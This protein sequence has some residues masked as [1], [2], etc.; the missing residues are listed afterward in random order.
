MAKKKKKKNSQVKTSPVNKISEA[1]RQK[2]KSGARGGLTAEGTLNTAAKKQAREENAKKQSILDELEQKRIARENSP[3][4]ET[5]RQKGLETKLSVIDKDRVARRNVYQPDEWKRTYTIE[6]TRSRPSDGV[7]KAATLTRALDE[8]IQQKR[9]YEKAQA[10]ANQYWKEQSRLAKE[11]GMP[12]LAY[13]KKQINDTPVSNQDIQKY[14]SAQ[15]AKQAKLNSY[16]NDIYQRK[17]SKLNQTAGANHV[18]WEA[19]KARLGDE[20]TVQGYNSMNQG[21]LN[22]RGQGIYDEGSNLIYKS[23]NGL[24]SYISDA[25][26]TAADLREQAED[27]R[28]K[29]RTGLFDYIE[30]IQQDNLERITRGNN[31]IEEQTK[32]NKELYDRRTTYQDRRIKAAETDPRKYVDPGVDPDMIISQLSDAAVFNMVTG[33]DYNTVMAGLNDA[34]KQQVNSLISETRENFR[35]HSWNN[36]ERDSLLKEA[37]AY[38]YAAQQGLNEKNTRNQIS[39][40]MTASGNYDDAAYD[41][42]LVNLT[43]YFADEYHDEAYY[44]PTGSKEDQAYYYM[45]NIP[46]VSAPENSIVNLRKEYFA[47]PEMVDAY[48][49]YYRA[50]KENGTNLAGAFLDAIEPYLTSWMTEYSD[51]F[52]RKK[53]ENPLTGIPMRIMSYPINAVMS[54]PNIINT[55]MA[56]LGNKG[57][58]DPNNGINQVNRF[59]TVTREEQNKDI[60]KALGGNGT[61]EYLLNVA[62]SIGDNVM[63]MGTA[64][65]LVPGMMSNAASQKLG[66]GIVQMIMSGEATGH[67]FLEKLA[68]N[69]NPTEAAW[70]AIG[71]GIIEWFTERVSLEALL[72]PDVKAML[73]DKKKLLKYFGTTAL[74]EGSEE[75]AADFLN[76]G[77]DYIISMAYDHQDELTKRYYEL[78]TSGEGMSARDAWNQALKEK[79]EQIGMSGLAGAISGGLMGMGR[80]GLNYIQNQNLGSQLQGSGKV[81]SLLNIGLQS[82]KGTLSRAN[83]EAIRA[84]QE[85]GKKASNFETGKLAQSIML[86][87]RESMDRKTEQARTESI[88]RDL[89][90]QG[91][92]AEEA[93]SLA[94]TI[95]KALDRGGIE[96]L[97]KKERDAIHGNQAAV[98]TLYKYTFDEQTYKNL[99]KEVNEKTKTEAGA[100]VSVSNMFRKP[101]T[102]NVSYNI[103]GRYQ[104]KEDDNDLQSAEGERTQGARG[105]IVYNGDKVQNARINGLMMEDGKLKWSVTIDGVKHYVDAKQIRTTDAGTAAIIESHANNPGF[106]NQKY[107]NRMLS[108]Y[109]GANTDINPGTFL[110]DAMRIRY[111]ALEQQEMPETQIPAE[112]AQELY[113]TAQTAYEEYRQNEQEKANV[114]KPGETKVYFKGAEAGTTEFDNA[115]N[116]SSLSDREKENIRTWAKLMK[117]AGGQDITFVDNDDIREMQKNRKDLQIFKGAESELYGEQS[118]SGI[119]INIE[120]QNFTRDLETGEKKATGRHNF[121]IALGHE[122]T[123]YIQTHTV[124]GW[125]E[126]SKYVMDEQRKAL[127]AAGLNEAISDYM[128]S[129]GISLEEAIAEYVADSCE[130]IFNNKDVLDHIQQ[131]NKTLFGQIRD[132]VKDLIDRVRNA[133]KNSQSSMTAA[134]MRMVNGNLRELAKRFNLAY[135]EA[136]SGRTENET[137]KGEEINRKSVAELSDGT[138][139]AI[140]DTNL[141]DLKP[142]SM[143]MS[144]F[145]YDYLR[146]H[147]NENEIAQATSDVIYLGADL[148]NEY[149]AS[150]YTKDLIRG[151]RKKL[152]IKNRAAGILLDAIVAADNKNGPNP[153]KHPK[154]KNAK[155]GVYKFNTK[156]AFPVKDRAGNIASYNVYSAQLIVNH[157]SNGKLELYDIM[158]INSDNQSALKM[159]NESAHGTIKMIRQPR[160]VTY[161]KVSQTNQ[162]SKTNKS[163]AQLDEAYMAAVESGNEAEQLALVDEAARRAGFTDLAYHGTKMFGFTEFNL[164]AGQGTIFVSFNEKLARSYTSAGE[165]RTIDSRTEVPVNHYILNDEELSQYAKETLEQYGSGDIVDI[166]RDPSENSSAEKTAE[167]RFIIQ[168]KNYKGEIETARPRR[169][170]LY[171]WIEYRT[172]PNAELDGIYQLYTRPGKQL[173]VDAEGNEWNNVPFDLY[174][175]KFT[176]N[177]LLGE[178]SWTYTDTEWDNEFDHDEVHEDFA[179]TRE[180]AKWAKAHGY[181]SVRINNVSDNGGRNIELWNNGEDR[182][183]GDIGIFFNQ[184]DVKS[185]DPITYDDNG[186]VIPP[187]ERFNDEKTDIR[188]S[189]ALTEEQQATVDAAEAEGID[190]DVVNHTA[191]MFSRASFERSEYYKNPEEMARMLAKNVLGSESKENIAKATK[192]IQDVTSISAMIADNPDLLDYIAS[193]GRSSFK[194]NPEYG[195]SID[196]STICAKRRL[197]TGTIDAIQRAM[198][199]YVMSAEDFLQI[200][201]MMKDRGYEV[202]CGLCFVESSRKNIAKYASQFMREWNSQHPENKVNMTQINTVLGLEDTR[203]NNKEVY[204][205]YEKFMNKLAQRKPKLFEMRSEYDNDII[206][207]FRNDDSVAEK[208]K[209]GGLRINSFSDFEIV[210]LIDMMQVIMDMSNVGLAGQAYTK[211]REFAEALGPT[212]LKINMSM[213][214]AGVD[215]NGRIIFDEVEGMKWSDVEDLRN[216]Y[217]DNVGTVCVVFTEEQLLAAMADERIDFINPFHRSQWNKSNY[218]DIGLPENVKDFTYWQNERYAKPVY[219]TKKDGTLKKLRATN[220]MPNEYWNPNLSG[221]ENAEAYLKMCYENNKIPKFWKWLQSNGDGSFSLKADGSTDGYWKLLGDFKMYNHLTGDYAAQMPVKPEF[222]MDASERMLREYKGGHESFPEAS[223][224]VQDFVKEK[225]QGRKGLST[226]KNGRIQ[227]AGNEIANSRL[228]RWTES[229]MDVNYWMEHVT[230][231]ALQTE[232]EWQMVQVYRGKRTSMALSLK[233]QLDMK[234]QIRQIE[235][236]TELTFDDREALAKLRTNLKTEQDKYARLEDEIAE[237]T[238][239]SGWAGIMRQHNVIYRDYM[240]GKTQEQVQAAV[241]SLTEE[242]KRSEKAIAKQEK[243][244]AKM[245]A[246]SAVQTVKKLLARKGLARTAS[247]LRSEYSTAMS[248]EELK[249]RLAEIVV[250]SANGEDITAEVEA[251]AT[252]VITYQVG[253]ANEAADEQLYPLRGMTVE[254]SPAQMQELK[255][256][257][258]SLAELRRKTK[259]SGVRF[260]EGERFTLESNIQEIMDENPAL[261][262]KLENA[263]DS[264][265]NFVDYVEGLLKLK[266]QQAAADI[267]QAELESF[268]TAS[269]NIML[270]EEAGGM[271]KKQLTNAIR[272]EADKIGKALAAVRGVRESVAG[273]KAAGQ[274][275]QTWAGMLNEDTQQ[276]LKYYNKMARLAAETERKRVKENVIKSLKSEHAKAMLQQAEKFREQMAN[277]KKARELQQDNEALREKISTV[278]TRMANRIFAE[279]DRENVPEETKALVRQVLDMVSKH[280]WAFRKVTYW[281]KQRVDNVRQRLT[282]MIANYGQFDPETDLDWLVVKT[283]D[284]RDNDYTARDKVEQDLVDIETGL[285]EYRNAEGQGRISLAD[286]KAALT[287]VQNALSEIWNVIKARSEMEIAGRKW[288]VIEL[289]EWMRGEMENSRFKGERKG[290]GSRARNTVSG[291]VTWGNLTP[292]YFFKNLKNRAMEQLHKGLKIAEDRSGLEAAKA[293]ERLAQIAQEDGFSSW[294]GQE[295]HKVQT[296]SGEI[297]MTTEQIMALYAT[298]LRESSQMRPA[299]TAH[300]LHGGFVLAEKENSKGMPGREKRSTRPIRM[301]KDQLNALN[302]HLTQEQTKYV[303]DMV[304]YMSGELAELGNEASMKM[305]GIKKFTEQ[306]YYP[307]K[308]WGGVLNKRSDAG[309][310]SNN[311]NRAAQM[312]SSKRVKNNASN[313]IQIADFTPTAIKHVAEMITYNTVAPAIE[314]LNKV[315]NQQLQYGEVKYTPDGAEVDLDDTYKLNMRAAFENAYG[316]QASDYLAKFMKDMNGGVTT[317]RNAFDKLLSIFKKNAVAGSLSVAAQQ[318][319]SYIRA[320]MMINP[321][322]LAAAISPQYWKGSFAEMMKHSGLAVIKQMGKF[323]MNFGQTM[324]EWITPEGMESKAKKAWNKTTDLITGLPGAMDAM[325]WTRMWTAVKLEQ[326]AQNKGMDFTSDEFMA[327]VAERFNDLMRQTQVYDS[328]MTKSQNMRSQHWYAKTLTSF[329]AEPTLSLNVLADAFQNIKEKGGKAK[330]A[331]AVATFLLSAAAQAGA[332][333]FFGT[334]RSPDKKKNKEENFLN[335]FAYNLLSEANPFGL[336]PAYRQIVETLTDGEMKDDTMGMIAKAGEVVENIFKLATGQ[337][338]KKG[339]Y[340]DLEDSIGQMLQLTTEIPAKN[341]MR[342]FRAMVNFFSN[343]G[344]KGLTGDTYA[345][346]ETS[347]AMLKYQ[348]LDTLMTND[349]IGLINAK[350]ADAGYQT[351]N[352]AY[353]QRIVDAEKSGNQQAA[354]QMK[355]YLVLK[356]NAEDPEKSVNDAIRKLYKTDDDLSAEERYQKQKEYGLKSGSGFITDEYE[357]GNLTRA[358]AEKLYRQENPKASDKDVLKVFDKIDWEKSGKDPE[359]Y[360][361]Y[362]PLYE[363]IG[364][365]RVE[366]IRAAVDHMVKNGYTK[367]EIKKQLTT[368]Y[369]QAYLDAKGNEKTRL[370]DALTKTYKVIG[371][372]A[373]EALKIINGWKP[374]KQ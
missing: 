118:I 271:N 361:N 145:I 241:D 12:E 189:R 146:D 181:D 351:T 59:T 60:D 202:S 87:S 355:E 131:T 234:A 205:A 359:G 103:T 70:S 127:G 327:K 15:N 299:D 108:L 229:G 130:S 289:A 208:N 346:R 176:G 157:N 245:E 319:L 230:P 68:N 362:T 366:E 9:A 18:G 259:G 314:N 313:A 209:R 50:D 150:D 5:G 45:N 154:N 307:I 109:D 356:S 246:E 201:R 21:R 129:R 333:A 369:K 236:K 91:V 301:S 123:H 206:K 320:A 221:K 40:M 24:N 47:T 153:A 137:T 278:S 156:L 303:H 336:I 203:I 4:T 373:E 51:Y 175:K 368:K 173:V 28:I 275:A 39:N 105:V 66:M 88:A 318:P 151:N 164:K 160:V 193:P 63:A 185:A 101:G 61:V 268:I 10:E 69:A 58:A 75:I 252:D 170:E 363:A 276:A 374:K 95:G 331:K 358:E 224:V 196:S 288:Q 121:G 256:K 26:K 135:D 126:L 291:A 238:S 337:I 199:D 204:D 96:N 228:S 225:K 257:G 306:F 260:A 290:F 3:T 371:L 53:A 216:K 328:V 342:D 180:I 13:V 190:L 315:L 267:D 187:S 334:G 231:S 310:S 329:M 237:I 220:Y 350:L 56:L 29:G 82:E 124:N 100:L 86:E 52:I 99:Q 244:L 242:V 177:V 125:N 169:F 37:E 272:Q 1:E 115:L 195:G 286:R 16:L 32:A 353:Y 6:P 38:D 54:I 341:I 285:M 210:H 62:D 212:G 365:N 107:I 119:L 227:L 171:E 298:W 80:A 197:Q 41:P 287:K 147:I 2:I 279:T 35:T 364:N 34:Q 349:M 248:E 67:T 214:A 266:Q 79:Y 133:M 19:N 308:S 110:M 85:S 143:K 128:N 71:D 140:E 325:T 226:G 251:L 309:I 77:L 253:A 22:E 168:Y 46:D 274:K 182:V 78:V 183:V 326:M 31:P 7:G 277:D 348:L 163:Q 14:G 217:A 219:G 112:M 345:Q 340:R 270:N 94:E 235:S 330:A 262:D 247:A 232:D 207:H 344:A 372:T 186:E 174:G 300:L 233:K 264:L 106:Y 116:K 295:E 282:R 305:Y 149:I 8:G 48:N 243:E 317:E 281:D 43:K 76:W 152:I 134:G 354:D 263:G 155:L 172:N 360:T 188:W 273:M 223:D 296:R 322:Y 352:A 254:L 113:Q 323:D 120:G 191:S 42:T 218:K 114:R 178:E 81:N 215:E 335:K 324:Q 302:R 27:A 55:G 321:K 239:D 339:L 142:E 65:A 159:L 332:K 311:E 30:Q 347:Q 280:D 25:N 72:K 49:R 74:A 44:E 304:A 338:G 98:N 57:A 194:S 250:R 64:K 104:I 139:I 213:I 370:M 158:D 148:P 249:N 294:D 198:P 132:Y 138:R 293:K 122:F 200:R 316:K 144:D 357:D 269:A 165:L 161:S 284:P 343:G 20:L 92:A 90:A 211:V 258:S 33:E 141:L 102:K 117:A 240:E 23:D 283:A 312:S 36:E 83:A 184:A 89:Q 261:R 11:A 292:E 111:A 93:E 162:N 222:D 97:S 192:W 167:D 255:A 179:S 73:G 367:D 265:D 297:T 166:Y 84:K 17:Q 136:I